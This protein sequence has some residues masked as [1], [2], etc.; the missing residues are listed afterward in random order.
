MFTFRQLANK[1]K[2]AVLQT[3]KPTPRAQA[4]KPAGVSAAAP[5]RHT[6]PE[7]AAAK[8]NHRFDH[9]VAINQPAAAKVPPGTSAPPGAVRCGICGRHCCCR[10]GTRTP[11]ATRQTHNGGGAGSGPQSDDERPSRQGCGGGRPAGRCIG[12][13][14]KDHRRGRRHPHHHPKVSLAI[15]NPPHAEASGMRFSVDAQEAR[16]RLALSRSCRRRT[17]FYA[18]ARHAAGGC[19]PTGD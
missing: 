4:A 6:A 2:G 8:Q 3:P 19:L 10:A 13:G 15:S 17:P 11:R 7:P 1:N 9:L 14:R 16:R 5:Q 12:D 18:F